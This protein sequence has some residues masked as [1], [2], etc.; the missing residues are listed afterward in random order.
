MRQHGCLGQ[1]FGIGIQEG[2]NAIEKLLVYNVRWVVIHRGGWNSDE[3]LGRSWAE[4]KRREEEVKLSQALISQSL[5]PIFS[6]SRRTVVLGERAV[7][8][9]LGNTLHPECGSGPE[10]AHARRF[11]VPFRCSI[12]PDL[13]D[14]HCG[15]TVLVQQLIS[16]APLHLV[17]ELATHCVV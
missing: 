13:V 6:Q 12:N 4:E 15:Y 14:T 1:W 11:L 17:L 16:C 10:C 5:A 3:R 2:L 7:S 9:K 8:Q